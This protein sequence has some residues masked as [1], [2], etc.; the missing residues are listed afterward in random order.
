MALTS[1]YM[2]LM[3]MYTSPL[4]EGGSTLHEETPPVCMHAMK[5]CIATSRWH[6]IMICP[7]ELNQ[8]PRSERGGVKSAH[9]NWTG[10]QGALTDLIDLSQ[11]SDMTDWPIT[12]VLWNLVQDLGLSEINTTGILHPCL[13]SAHRFPDCLLY[14]HLII[15]HTAFGLLACSSSWRD[16]RYYRY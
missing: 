15:I 13:H 8:L 1:I 5:M 3:W 16:Y 10:F 4:I 6:P 11:T 12:S 2:P 7:A 14:I 9:R